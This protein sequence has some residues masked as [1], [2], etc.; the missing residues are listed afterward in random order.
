MSKL[1]KYFLHNNRDL[2]RWEAYEDKKIPLPKHNNNRVF[3][4]ES[5]A[6]ASK[7]KGNGIRKGRNLYD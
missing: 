5:N 4:M 6:E 7:R 3:M 1:Q 2:Q